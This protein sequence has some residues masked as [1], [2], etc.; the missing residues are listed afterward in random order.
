MAKLEGRDI[1]G[2]H[3]NAWGKLDTSVIQ[4]YKKLGPKATNEELCEAV[5]EMLVQAVN[6]LYG[7]KKQ[8]KYIKIVDMLMM[9][10]RGALAKAVEQV[11]EHISDSID[12]SQLAIQVQKVIAEIV[13]KHEASRDED[14]D[15]KLQE[16]YDAVIQEIRKLNGSSI[17]Q[18]SSSSQQINVKTG[19]SSSILENSSSLYDNSSMALSLLAELQKTVNNGFSKIENL[20]TS[21]KIQKSVENI[22]TS[23]Q[24]PIDQQIIK[25]QSLN[26]KEVK[27]QVSLLNQ[28]IGQ[29]VSSQINP[30]KSE[31]DDNDNKA[32]QAKKKTYLKDVMTGK[33]FKM[34]KKLLDTQFN[35]IMLTCDASIKNVNQG[36]KD[37]NKHLE[38]LIKDRAKNGFSW[39]KLVMVMSLFLIPVLW[40]N[41]LDFFNTKL[42]PFIQQKFP[43]LTK[44]IDEHFDINKTI[45]SF[46]EKIDWMKHINTIRDKVW[47][48]IKNKFD[49]WIQNPMDEMIKLVKETY[50]SCMDFVHDLWEIVTGFFNGEDVKQEKKKLEDERI[51]R[52]DKKIQNILDKAEDRITGHVNKT[53]SEVTKAAE[54]STGEIKK[55]VQKTD[56]SIQENKQ[57]IEGQ[58]TQ[59]IQENNNANAKVSEMSTVALAGAQ[60]AVDKSMTT[61]ATKVGDITNSNAKQIEVQ[62]AQITKRLE[63]SGGHPST[64][65]QA[66]LDKAEK[67]M[68][69]NNN[70]QMRPPALD[71]SIDSLQNVQ[72]YTKVNLLARDNETGADAFIVEKDKLDS[73]FTNIDSNNHSLMIERLRNRE[74]FGKYQDDATAVSEYSTKQNQLAL[75]NYSNSKAIEDR[76]RKIRDK[77]A[78]KITSQSTTLSDTE[79]E[80]KL[81]GSVDRGINTITVHSEKIE[82]GL[83]TN[84]IIL[85]QI[86]DS[87]N[88]YFSALSGYVEDGKKNSN[89]SVNT[90]VIT[91]T[92]P[93]NASVDNPNMN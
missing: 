34:L 63:Q 49:K 11:Q 84:K 73:K 54:Q 77:Q 33:Q 6:V 60:S 58:F 8:L 5:K 10:V 1:N 61:I 7:D 45:D 32:K 26:E 67:I 68:D 31:N 17:V 48:K 82:E 89:V 66:E 65:T 20:I 36:F 37:I 91:F 83:K 3:A 59:S 69:E 2:M 19:N 9:R 14:Y 79:K 24:K 38:K 47:E 43:E 15:K 71:T 41:I 86:S 16:L 70:I 88:E 50:D 80:M 62:A 52:D 35:T 56:Q 92:T 29:D 51:K 93:V 44:W 22:V 30:F 4:P 90:G 81:Y 74:V 18:S 27:S 12:N 75:Q 78:E 21:S 55:S 23:T 40:Q 28:K 64:I 53:G 72:K 25:T 42:V 85:K 46:I 87:V 76:D 13:E 57:K 39:V